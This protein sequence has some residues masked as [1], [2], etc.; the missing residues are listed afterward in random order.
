MKATPVDGRILTPDK[1]GDSCNWVELARNGDYSLIVRAAF[2]NIYPNKVMYGN[3]VSGD[4]AWQNTNGFGPKN[5]YWTSNVR[6]YINAWF[7]GSSKG[8]ADKLAGTARL[9][10]FAMQP[11]TPMKLG[12]CANAVS[13]A[14][15]F[16][17]P[18]IYQTGEG[19][20]VAFALSY[21]EAAN[22][23]SKLYFQRNMY[24]A[25]QP[26]SSIA[27]ANYKKI[28]I[29][30]YNRSHMWLRS[31]GDVPKAVGTLSD[32]SNAFSA[33][34]VFQE[35]PTDVYG[36]VYPALW[37]GSGIFEPDKAKVTYHPNGGTGDVNVVKVAYGDNH[38]IFDQ[39][40]EKE[41]LIFG[42]WNSK[43][44]GSGT[45]Y[46]NGQ[47]VVVD[48]NMDLFAQWEAPVYVH[49]VYVPG[50]GFGNIVIDHVLLGSSYTIKSDSDI[51]VYKSAAHLFDGWNN[52]YFGEKYGI[53]TKYEP[54]QVI[55]V[56][57]DLVIYAQWFADGR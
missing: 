16:S 9:R 53:G 14:D 36:Y 18:T 47:T 34:R 35:Y 51:G 31:V 48:E 42:G 41:G 1:T 30:V 15:G 32:D 54:G 44:D 49:V 3:I 26:S 52:I 37:V 4:P 39:G 55:T 23:L 20:D 12:S 33:G 50:D 5:N 24:I 8:E 7:N 25:N 10:S 45:K 2:L 56:T 6:D 28:K 11:V 19:N 40:Y 27:V 13:L 29:P 57:Q 22:F 17:K 21:G 38:T 43:A 46:V